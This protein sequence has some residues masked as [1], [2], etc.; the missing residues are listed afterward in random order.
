MFEKKQDNY[1][2]QLGK[3]NRIVEGTTISGNIVSKAD[4]RL[5]G[6]L[7]GNIETDGKLVIGLAGK[8]IGDI[9]CLNADIEGHFTGNI[10][11]SQLLNVK[12]NAVIE[13]EVITA[14]LAVEPGAVFTATCV[15][16][17]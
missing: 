16:K 5:D 17:Q 1:T 14:K 4:L 9:I 2:D 15:M 13:G 11:V 6:F 8:V 3:T 10:K 7:T 12:T